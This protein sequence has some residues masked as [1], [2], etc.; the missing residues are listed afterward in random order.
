Q[1]FPV[2]KLPFARAV[3]PGEL[4][5]RNVFE[6]YAG[7]PTIPDYIRRGLAGESFLYTVTIESLTYDT[8]IISLRDAAGRQT[9]IA[10]MSSNVTEIRQLQARA[11]QHDH[12]VALGMLAASV[13]HE[14]NNPLT[15][16]LG[17]AE[18]L[19]REVARLDQFLGPDRSPAIDAAIARLKREL[20]PVTEGAARI[21]TITRDLRTFSRP[22]D[23]RSVIRID[24]VLRSAFQLVGKELEARARL[25]IRLEAEAAVYANHAR[26]LQV[27]LNLLTN[28]VQAL[29]TGGDHEIGVATRVEGTRVVV[30]VSDTGPGVPEELRA[31]IFEPFV[32]TKEVGEGTGLGLFVCRNLV[33]ALGGT[34][35]VHHR[36]GGGAL[37]RVMLP[38]QHAAPLTTPEP[39]APLPP[40]PI[41]ILVIDDD[42]L[43]LRAL[44]GKLAEIPSYTVASAE[45]SRRALDLLQNETFDLIYCDLMMRGMTGMALERTLREQG[46]S[47][48]D[49]LVFMTGGA[50]TPEAQAFVRANT[51]RVVDKPLDIVAETERRVR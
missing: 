40:T 43:V 47:N 3:K 5:G 41:K 20:V 1:H 30:E 4:V 16:V 50:F 8:W 48:A 7:H 27:F 13:A 29:P 31:R 12:Q 32:T 51:A 10:A 26:L 11:I 38:I 46:S 36:P 42:P 35:D 18:S 37:F 14:I 23:E 17:S 33:T 22:D 19:S 2:E 34:I 44:V 9:G 39:P 49:R 6:L 28:A 21:A 25:V 45:D 15:Y 24:E